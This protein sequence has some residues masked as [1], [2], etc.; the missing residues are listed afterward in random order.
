[1]VSWSSCFLSLYYQ[2]FHCLF[3]LQKFVDDST[4]SKRQKKALQYDTDEDEDESMKSDSEENRDEDLDE[5]ADKQEGGY[6]SEKEKSGKKLPKVKE[7]SGKKKADT[8]SGHKSGPPKKI[9]KSP[10]KKVSSKI[11]EEKESPNDS[12]KVFSRKKKPTA[13][14]EIKGKKSSGKVVTLISIPKCPLFV[15]VWK[16]PVQFI[17][18]PLWFII[19]RN[20]PCLLFWWIFLLIFFLVVV[21]DHHV[22]IALRYICL[23]FCLC[24]GHRDISL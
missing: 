13:E 14:K 24:L 17:F 3:L 12:A 6:G 9:I 5:A 8:G 21:V 22:V 1:M 16:F 2:H 23:L 19:S 15:G 7:S 4:S 20:H 10:V 18:T 11:H